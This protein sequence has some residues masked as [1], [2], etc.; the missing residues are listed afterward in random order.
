MD[1]KDLKWKDIPGF[2]G[3]YQVSTDGTVKSIPHVIS[4]GTRFE[5]ISKEHIIKPYLD[6]DGYLLVKLCKHGVVS[7]HRV[8]RL[9]ALAF[10]PNPDDLPEIN[11]K[12]ENKVNNHPDNLEWCTKAYN[13]RY[14]TRT[15]RTSKRV[16]QLSLNGTLLCMYNS[17]REASRETGI[18][19]CNIRNCASGKL[20]HNK[21]G[22]YIARTAGGFKWKFENN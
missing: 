18:A 12:D 17:V 16:C 5:H 21:K 10:V 20:I 7:T 15:Q 9:V 22:D 11:H 8:H 14:G 13:T 4:Q 1:C 6:D 19:P 3:Y 2:E